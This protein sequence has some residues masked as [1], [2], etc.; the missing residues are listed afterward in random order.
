MLEA[1]VRKEEPRH[2]RVQAVRQSVSS[3]RGPIVLRCQTLVSF[4]DFLYPFGSQT[5]PFYLDYVFAKPGVIWLFRLPEGCLL[6][7]WS[8]ALETLR[9]EYLV[10]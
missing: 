9:L 6:L 2:A 10:Q 5:L 1:H 3:T 4:R 8:A 7:Q